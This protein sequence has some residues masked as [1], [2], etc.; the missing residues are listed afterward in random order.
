MAGASG[1]DLVQDGL[2]L[3]VDAADKNSYVGSGT[4][5]RDLSGNSNN[6]TLT[7]GPTF[8]VSNYGN[9]LFDGTNDYVSIPYNSGL[10]PNNL[11]LSV[12]INRTSAVYYAHFIGIPVSNTTWTSPFTSYGIEYIGT[13]DTI[14]FVTGY[15]DNNFDYTNVTSFGNGVW[16][17]FTATYDKS[18]VK[19][20][21]NGTL[22]TTRAET[23][24]LYASTA[25][26]YIGSNNM[27]SEYP[28]NGKIANTLLYNR[29]LSATEVLQNYNATKTRF[30][31]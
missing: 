9:I 17:H 24:T 3:A 31:L 22:Q 25:N 23:R 12:W 27:T 6:G 4:T 15:T 13:T 7:N 21:I 5:W 29:S 16:F 19:I 8:N 2:V 26:F 28:F 14:S 11:T 10:I 1:P 18:N 20:Y 30:G